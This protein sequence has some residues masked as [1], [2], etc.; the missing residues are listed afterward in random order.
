MGVNTLLFNPS[1]NTNIGIGIAIAIEQVQPF[2]VALQQGDASLVTQ[3]QPEDNSNST[4]LQQL[5]LDGQ[6]VTATLKSGDNVLANNTYYHVYA[7][8]GRAGQQ[9]TIEMNSKQIDS[10]LFLVSSDGKKIVEQNDDISSKNFNARL[11]AKL[12]AE[13]RYY[14]I[15]NAFERGE[16]GKYSLRASIK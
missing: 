1:S 15:A 5:P 11:V 13:G 2:L 8:E 3:R 16:S 12:P 4:P 14:A 10:A 7:F 9:V 6:P